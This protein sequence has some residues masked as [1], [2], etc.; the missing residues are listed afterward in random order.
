M[1]ILVTLS[2]L[3]KRTHWGQHGTYF[4]R[5]LPG[6]PKPVEE[7]D[8]EPVFRFSEVIAWDRLRPVEA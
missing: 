1:D 6:F 7:I 3:A 8:G 5:Q 2:E 4:N